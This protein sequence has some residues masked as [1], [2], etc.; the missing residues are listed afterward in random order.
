MRKG[1]LSCHFEAIVACYR[2]DKLATAAADGCENPEPFSRTIYDTFDL[3]RTAVKV[4]A[5]EELS[6]TASG[7]LDYQHFG[8]FRWA[9]PNGI[10][11]AMS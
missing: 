10:E 1:F 8:G 4:V 3:L 6:R 7:K 9:T 5:V 2:R 11:K